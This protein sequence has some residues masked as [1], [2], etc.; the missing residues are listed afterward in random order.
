MVHTINIPII[1]TLIRLIF[2]PFLLPLLL[3]HF[4]PFNIFWINAILA[5]FFVMVCLTD[6]FDGYLARK[7]KQETVLGKLLDP[8]ADKF[9]LYSTLIVLLSV[10]KIFFYWPSILIGREFLVMGI[11]LIAME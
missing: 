11:R 1:L 8:I 6:F 2:S 4:L 3:V 9:L 10:H 7:Y 5:L